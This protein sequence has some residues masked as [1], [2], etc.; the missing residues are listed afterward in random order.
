MAVKLD[1]MQWNSDGFKEVLESEEVRNLIESEARKFQSKANA[2]N[3]RDSEGYEVITEKSTY[4]GGRWVSRVKSI[5]READIAESEDK[6]L[7]RALK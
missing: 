3:S 7:S 2:N 4:G 6:A 5:D 1:R